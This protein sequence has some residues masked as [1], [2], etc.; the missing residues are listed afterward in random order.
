MK[1]FKIYLMASLLVLVASISMYWNGSRK[2]KT[3]A[4]DD[5]DEKILKLEEKLEACLKT[6]NVTDCK[7][8]TKELEAW[9]NLAESCVSRKTEIKDKK[10]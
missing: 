9:K 2:T 5:K 8:A 7:N 3:R 4:L 10:M 1:A 6:K